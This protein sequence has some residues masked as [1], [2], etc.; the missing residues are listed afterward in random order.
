MEKKSSMGCFFFLKSGGC[1]KITGIHYAEGSEIPKRSRQLV[2]RAAVEMSKTTS[3]LALQVC[4][5]H[6]YNIATTHLLFYHRFCGE[7]SYLVWQHASVMETILMFVRLFLTTINLAL[8]S[9]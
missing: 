2:W 3:Q 1:R 5:H 4:Y 8:A 9:G 7:I 6:L